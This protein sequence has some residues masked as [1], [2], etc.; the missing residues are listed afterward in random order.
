MEDK[1][2]QEKCGIVSFYTPRLTR[3]LRFSLLA[4][5]GVQHRGQH[6]AGVAMQ[7]KDSLIKYTKNGL[8]RE[9]FTQEIVK[10]LNQPNYWTIIH[11]RYGTNGSYMRLN[12]QPCIAQL[13]KFKMAVAHNGE[14]VATDKIR[15]KIVT[16][17]PAGASDTYLFTLLLSQARGKTYEDKILSTLSQVKGAYSLIIGVEDKLYAI[18]DPFGIRPLFIGQTKDGWLIASETH[19]FTK[20][21]IK[22]K[23]E[24]KRGEIIRLDKNGLTT[25]RRW[26]NST[27][28][29]CDFEW[30]YFERPDSR[31]PTHE[32]TNKNNDPQHWLS[33][34]TFRERCGV[35]L[36]Q[37]A[38]IKKATF[39]VGVPDSGI[40]I[41]NGYA[42]A[43]N[44][45]YRQVIIRD[46]FDTHGSH[47]LFMK[48]DQKDKIAIK[49]LG[50]LSLVPDPTIWKKAIVVVGDDSI[51]RGN[52]S[53]Q[54]TR[55]IFKLGAKEVHWILGFP[56]VCHRCHL[57]VSMRTREELIAA[58]NDANPHKIAKAIGATSVNYISI[59]GFIQAR[60]LLNRI[61]ITKDPKEMFLF[62]GG[63]GGCV[64]GVYPI[65]R[66]G[67]IYSPFVKKIAVL[68]S[69][70]GTGT[71]LQ[72]IIDAIEQGKLK[73]KIAVVVSDAEDAYGLVRAKKHQIP[74]FIVDKNNSHSL[75]QILKEKYKVDYIALAGWKQIIS[76]AIIREFYNK[77]LNI[78]PGLIPDSVK[79]IV[80]NPD[81]TRG[82]WN[83][84]KFTDSA[85]MNFFKNKCT[86]AGSSVHFL[87]KKLDFGPVLARCFEKIR[88]SDTV[89]S[90]YSRLKK[91]EHKI[92]VKTLK[93]LCD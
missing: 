23:R 13:G 41:G 73:A 21:A 84:G 42:N 69:N 86:Y 66:D 76:E 90:L 64:T 54:I 29:F 72:A 53:S 18:R 14:F 2:L 27:S 79:G 49:V 36:S 32:K 48:D 71:N 75:V 38:P 6:G 93:K 61:K 85:I 45:P 83:R 43:L 55:A 62:N 1:P 91:K 80:K 88:P 50:K 89:E 20:V 68:I 47:R 35:I 28:H 39:V 57:G 3:K 81:G 65:S 10:K 56:P 33:L 30:A 24:V 16:K 11:C 9:I 78:H 44:L 77:I 25:I 60:S 7:T 51:I 15:E 74:T 17:I 40:G 58:Q 70:A 8:L 26:R 87:T 63:C 22:V 5:G 19:A 52:V 46:H 31:L 67:K 37:E 34:S 92:Y 59:K 82:L 12:L 4:A